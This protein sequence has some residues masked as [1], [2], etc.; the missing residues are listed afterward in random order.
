MRIRTT[1]VRTR[2]MGAVVS[3]VLGA[4][5]LAGCSSSSESEEEAGGSSSSAAASVEGAQKAAAVLAAD[6]EAHDGDLSASGAED[7]TLDGKSVTLTEG[8]T[9]RLSGKLSDGQVLVNAPD[10]KVTLI[11]DGVDISS[12]SGAAIAATE[13]EELVVVLADG[14]ENTLSDADSYEEDA[15]ANA[16]LFSA[17]DLTVGGEGSLT[18]HGN[19]NDG[20]VSKDGLV[21]ASGTVTVEAA[22][23]GVRGKDYL[24]VKGGSVK[25]SAQGDGLKSD[26]AEDTKAGYI[27][28]S[29]GTVQV[30][31]AGDGVDAATDLVVTGGTLDVTAKAADDSSAHGLKS[32][33]ITVL[34]KGT[35]EIDASADGLHS[36]AAVHLDGAKVTVAAGDDGVHAEGDLVISEGAVEI[37]R[38]NEGLEGKD[39]TVAGGSTKVT[40]GDDGVNASGSTTSSDDQGDDQGGGQGGGPGGGGPG[41]GGGGE[42]V[43]DYSLKVTG[44][45][46]VI[47]ADGDGFDSNGTA[48]IT[49]GTLVVN[50][51]ETGGNGA[52]DVNGSFTVSGGVLLAAGSAGMAVAPDE[53]SGQGWLSVTL[54][55]TV[56]AGTTLHVVDSDGEVVA[57]YVTSKAIQN[58]VYSSSALKSGSE[59]RIWSGGKASG[60]E[61][62]GMYAA[63]DL[64]G[65]DEIATVTAGD[66]PE[67]GFGGGP[68]R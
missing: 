56:E 59:Y 37:T 30:T 24:V 25:V 34:E 5:A 12:S 45:T 46:L 20:I 33:V 36:D 7:V 60:E 29:A 8:G 27:A 22:D 26:N 31:A 50:G 58:V 61:S 23:D 41:G 16:A 53:E 11:L 35:V 18:V 38:S 67:G 3:A 14:S 57:S 9:Y 62:G 68:R 43:G 65:A 47:D 55:S 15:D 1:S 17:G 21:I 28:L 2:A 4:A 40:S 19:G 6:K 54:D 48:E 49:G 44:G 13:V 10:Q 64:D 63:G 66:A 39:I 42:S 32:G 51:P 52:L